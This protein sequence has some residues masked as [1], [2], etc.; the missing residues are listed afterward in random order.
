MRAI[1]SALLLWAVGCQDPDPPAT[2][3]YDEQISPIFQ[4]SCVGQTTGCHVTDD[5]G[6][7]AGNLD[8]S[9]YDALARR[10]DVL[11]PYGP[12]SRGLLFLKAGEPTDVTV[13]TLDPPDPARPDVRSVVIRTDV[14][15]N[16]G[17]GLQTVPGSRTLTDGT[18]SLV[19]YHL[20][21]NPHSD[22]LLMAYL[23]KE[24]VLIEA[25]AWSPEGAGYHPYAANLLEHIRRLKLDV[26]R[27]VPLHGA[28][29]TLKALEAVV[30]QQ[31]PSAA[32]STP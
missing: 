21:G 27:I 12:Y 10:F 20:A 9:S 29:A 14:R 19:L 13:D 1:L 23:P 28:P 31:A 30:Q 8:L 32:S 22:T 5:R 15:H 24:R 4:S 6:T 2:T 16:A 3:Y 26:A 17:L 25:D 7:A 11:R 18:R